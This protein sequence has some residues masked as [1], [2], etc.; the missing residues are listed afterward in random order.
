MAKL[1]DTQ[2]VILSAASQRDDRG[3]ELPTNVKGEVA[4]K[5][6]PQQR[7]WPQENTP[8]DGAPVASFQQRVS[9]ANRRHVSS[10]SHAPIFRMAFPSVGLVVL[11]YVPQ[12][13]AGRQTRFNAC[14]IGFV[15]SLVLSDQ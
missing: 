5:V 10:T 7:D 1:T 6:V 4:R 12:M 14:G 8:Q 11:S 3:V 15:G 9:Q 13:S 2:L